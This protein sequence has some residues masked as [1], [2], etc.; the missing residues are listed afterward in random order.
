M[1]C[2]QKKQDRKCRYSTRLA[3]NKVVTLLWQVTT[4]FTTLISSFIYF[5]KH[6][7]FI[8][9]ILI[10]INH[11]FNNN[12]RKPSFEQCFNITALLRYLICCNFPCLTP[13]HHYFTFYPCFIARWSKLFS[14]W[15]IDPELINKISRPRAFKW[16]RPI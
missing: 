7:H 15:G 16:G 1:L 2:C 5:T 14:V 4:L 8:S 11:C 3:E 13:S 6:N 12:S 10:F 9:D